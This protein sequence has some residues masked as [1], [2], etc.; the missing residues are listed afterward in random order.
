MR[1]P[2]MGGPHP[3]ASCISS[4]AELSRVLDAKVSLQMV[5][6]DEDPVAVETNPSKAHSETPRAAV[7]LRMLRPS[8]PTRLH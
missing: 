7:P 1:L 4:I 3:R 2:G 6:E 8:A 5:A